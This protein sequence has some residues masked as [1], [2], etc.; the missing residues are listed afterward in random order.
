MEC[1]A[2]AKKFNEKKSEIEWDWM[3]V[4]EEEGEGE[5]ERGERGER[6]RVKNVQIY[7]LGF[8]RKEITW[9]FCDQVRDFLQQKFLN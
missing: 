4:R 5:R 7:S 3:I 8:D 9:I 1:R 6:T 2:G